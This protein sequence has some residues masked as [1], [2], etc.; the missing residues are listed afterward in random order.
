[1]KRPLAALF[2]LSAL[3][4]GPI[5]ARADSKSD[6]A[7]LYPRMS[8][9]MMKKDMDGV[10]R[11]G[12]PD[13]KMKSN[14]RITEAKVLLGQM[15]QQLAMITMKSCSMKPESIKVKGDK[16]EVIANESTAMEFK[17]QDGIKH[18]LSSKGRS[19][20]TLV[21]TPGGWKFQFVETLNEKMTLDGKPFDPTAPPV[22]PIGS[23]FNGT[24][25][26]GSPF[27][28]KK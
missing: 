18:A 9:L 12:T 3:G 15:K 27:G 11:M 16:A 23:P 8:V 5:A 17:L 19:K 1:M 4:V 14:G 6:I 25:F 20:A 22:N 28:G 2:A 21:K 26:G 7:N 10:I 24:P 13:F